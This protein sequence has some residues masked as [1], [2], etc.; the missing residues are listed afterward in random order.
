MNAVVRRIR[1]LEDQF[2]PAIQPNFL[3]NPRHRLRIVVSGMNRG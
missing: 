1:R 2:R 3:R